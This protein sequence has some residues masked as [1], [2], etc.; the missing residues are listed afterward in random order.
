M[1]FWYFFA[2]HVLDGGNG[3]GWMETAKKSL[4]KPKKPRKKE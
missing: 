2:V 4:L 1:F 3:I